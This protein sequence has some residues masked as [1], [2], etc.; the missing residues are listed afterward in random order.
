MTK[1]TSPVTVDNWCVNG[2]ILT[3]RGFPKTAS[4]PSTIG[5]AGFCVAAPRAG[6]SESRALNRTTR[7]VVAFGELIRAALAGALHASP[8]HLDHVRVL[9][10]VHVHGRERFD[11]ELVVLD[12]ILV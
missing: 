8:D 7:E 12:Q 6:S 5:D 10:D 1:R 3:E 11:V 4:T 9:H 2:V